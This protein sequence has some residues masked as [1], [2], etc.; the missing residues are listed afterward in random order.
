MDFSHANHE[1]SLLPFESRRPASHQ[2]KVKSQSV[3][4]LNIQGSHHLIPF[5]SK[6]EAQPNLYKPTNGL[7]EKQAGAE[8]C[9]AQ[10]SIS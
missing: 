8:L 9:Q 1:L 7:N 4:E 2:A 10:H 3:A 5:L 6:K